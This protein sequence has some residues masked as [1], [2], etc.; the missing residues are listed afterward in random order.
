MH[1]KAELFIF[2]CTLVPHLTVSSEQGGFSMAHGACESAKINFGDFPPAC[3]CVFSFAGT[4]L[5]SAYI[6]GHIALSV[7]DGN[8]AYFH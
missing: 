2:V 7:L 4:N 8:S 5:N 6:T 3:I 1:H